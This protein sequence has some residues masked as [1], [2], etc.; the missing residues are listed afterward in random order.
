MET[1]GTLYQEGLQI[2]GKRPKSGNYIDF[3]DKQIIYAWAQRC[4]KFLKGS[5]YVDERISQLEE[6]SKKLGVK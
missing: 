1:I 5:D 3:P 4:L 2:Q 6:A